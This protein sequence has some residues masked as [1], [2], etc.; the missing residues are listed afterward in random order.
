MSTGRNVRVNHPNYVRVTPSLWVEGPVVQGEGLYACF[1]DGSCIAPDTCRCAEGWTGYDCNTPHCNPTCLNGGVCGDKDTCVCPTWPTL[2]PEAHPDILQVPTGFN[3]SD[4]GMPM[5]A[6]GF[7]ESNC[8]DE[9]RALAGITG[10]STACYMCSNGGVCSAPDTCSCPP[11]WTGFDCQTPVCSQHADVTTL[12]QLNTVD[13]AVVLTFELDPCMSTVMEQFEPE[14]LLKGRGNCTAPDVCTCFCRL[15]TWFDPDGIIVEKP[16]VDDLSRPLEPDQVYG[17]YTCLD[18]YEGS[19]NGRER[20]TSCH[21]RI[22]VPTFVER[23]TP[24]MVAVIISVLVVM[25]VVYAGVRWQLL[26][27]AKAYRK[28]RRRQRDKDDDDVDLDKEARKA[29]GRK[30]AK[31][32]KDKKPKSKKKGTKKS[33]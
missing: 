11:Q 28:K 30:K 21:L 9:A 13:P 16:W 14:G 25:V 7:F 24:V 8:T 3:G 12:D 27:R 29:R 10:N 15:P 1:N 18:G 19:L 2:L 5:C 6:Q 20:F 17:R 23:Y 4:C 33:V 22:K 31:K 32:S 26:R